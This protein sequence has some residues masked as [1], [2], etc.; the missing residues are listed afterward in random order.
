MENAETNRLAHQVARLGVLDIYLLEHP[1]PRWGMTAN[2]YILVQGPRWA[3]IDTG[4]PGSSGARLW[5][6]S[7]KQL[8]LQW[9]E[10]QSVWIT[11]AH[12]DHIG[13]ARHLFERSGCPPSI[14]PN[15][16][17][18]FRFAQSRASNDKDGIFAD[19]LTRSGLTFSD[20]TRVP[21]L[22]TSYNQITV[23]PDFLPLRET[24]TL[25]FGSETFQ[26]ILCTGHCKGHICIWH[27]STRTLFVGDMVLSNGFSP[28]VAMPGTSENPMEEYLAALAQLRTLKAGLFLGGHGKP[29]FQPNIRLDESLNFHH[30]Q[31][32]RIA[33][34]LSETSLS[35]AAVATI[36]QH[37]DIPF[38]TLSRFG[39][40]Q[41]LAEIVAYL[42]YLVTQDIIV[43][44]QS[45][46]PGV[47]QYC[48]YSRDGL[49]NKP[50][51]EC[52]E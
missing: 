48:P 39:K 25:A 46:P 20:G 37:R 18:E 7:A 16:L 10:L 52:D 35:A 29:L 8:G 47:V 13:Q 17:A 41:V 4:W 33:G 34:I 22:F 23:P 45:N 26:P 21:N 9:S 30:S 32:N 44:N 11:H 40:V 38:S 27:S 24:K 28:I 14:H 51:T 19:L 6:N 5:D 31:I 36:L 43:T 3:V 2:S 12:P 50:F 1:P 42:H 15:A 49:S